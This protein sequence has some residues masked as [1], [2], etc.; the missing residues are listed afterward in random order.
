MNART[1]VRAIRESV[2]KTVAPA[3]TESLESPPGRRPDAELV[4]LS[5]WFRTLGSSD[6]ANVTAVADMAA[7]LATYNFLLVLD[8][9]RAIEPVGPKGQLERSSPRQEPSVDCRASMSARS[10]GRPAARWFLMNVLRPSKGTVCEPRGACTRSD[11]TS[12]HPTPLIV[13]IT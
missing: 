12:S 6:R 3:V 1:F 10:F 9:L 4:R 13:L 2:Y 8:G 5:E 11:Q 7:D